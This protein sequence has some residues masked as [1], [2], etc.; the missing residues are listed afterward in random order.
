MGKKVG[1]R[2]LWKDLKLVVEPWIDGAISAIAGVLSYSQPQTLT[3]T[4]Q[5]QALSNL[6]VSGPPLTEVAVS[7]PLAGKGTTGD[8]LT[9]PAQLWEISA[10]LLI[11]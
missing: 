2:T 7:S 1:S 6:G 8:P 5:A 9:T 10:G 3:P 11:N 4:E